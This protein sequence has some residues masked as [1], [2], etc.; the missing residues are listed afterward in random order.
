MIQSVHMAY[1]ICDQKEA[2]CAN[3]LDRSYWNHW[4]IDCFTTV[5]DDGN[6][7]QVR[8]PKPERPITMR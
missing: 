6:S 3:V 5:A 4:L 2:L 7:S 8:S 1:D